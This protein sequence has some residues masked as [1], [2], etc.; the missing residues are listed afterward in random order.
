MIAADFV[1][2]FIPSACHTVIRDKLSEEGAAGTVDG[3]YFLHW[4]KE[5]L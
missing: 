2:R 3:D 4:I 1:N 5:Y